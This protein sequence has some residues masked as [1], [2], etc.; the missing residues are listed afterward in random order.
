MVSIESVITIHMKKRKETSAGGIVYKKENSGI[1]WLI[2]QH[3][4]HK[5]WGFP[6]GIVGDVIQ[7]E[8]SFEAA[9]REVE[10]EGGI[11]ARIMYPNP[12]EVKYTYTDHEGYTVDKNVMFYLME[13]IS[14]SPDDHD[15]EVS[16]ARFATEEDVRNTLTYD[17][18][19]EAF[20]NI[21]VLYTSLH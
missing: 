5:G 2:T 21:L 16:E 12:I 6:K 19:K 10:E 20:E 7:N 17:A 1:V 4:L 3:S 8:P 11:K 18:D 14:G 9:L 13:Y 15:W